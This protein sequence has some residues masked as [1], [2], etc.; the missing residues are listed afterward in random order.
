[1]VRRMCEIGL[2]DGIS[3]LASQERKYCLLMHLW[4]VD[5]TGMKL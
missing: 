1:M 3:Q 2:C 5:H 4:R